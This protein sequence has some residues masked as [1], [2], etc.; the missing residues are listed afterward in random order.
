MKD[1]LLQLVSGTPNEAVAVAG[2][3]FGAEVLRFAKQGRRVF[4]FEPMPDSVSRL[5]KIMDSAQ[6]KLDIQLFAVATSDKYGPGEFLEVAYNRKSKRV[7]AERMDRL[8]PQNVNISVLSVDIQGAEFAAIRGASGF[9][10][11]VKSLWIEIFGC[12]KENLKLFEYL[13]DQYV[14]FDFAPWGE[15]KGKSWEKD[16]ATSKSKMFEREAFLFSASRPGDYVGYL[17]WLCDTR[18]EKFNWLQTDIVAIRRDLFL[19]SEGEQMVK[20]IDNL[21]VSGCSNNKCAL[22][23]LAAKE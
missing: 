15:P 5:Q 16:P 8:V 13:D 10:P 22:R 1:G 17:K 20:D 18:R 4:A 6:P 12:G 21:H 19:G 9:L 3:S 23:N 7:A 2:V 11:R 14:L